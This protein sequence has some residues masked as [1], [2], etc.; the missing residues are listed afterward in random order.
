MHPPKATPNRRGSSNLT[1][2]C[3]SIG[4]GTGRVYGARLGNSTDTRCCAATAPSSDAQ[5]QR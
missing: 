3:A 4:V 2:A 5:L 1:A